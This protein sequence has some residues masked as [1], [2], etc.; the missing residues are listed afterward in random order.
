MPTYASL[1]IGEVVTGGKQQAD[2][3]EREY[4]WFCADIDTVSLFFF[5]LF[6]FL[7]FSSWAFSS[8]CRLNCSSSSKCIS[9]SGSPSAP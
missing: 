8:S 6:L 1:G 2:E 9:A 5:F 3:K 4:V 7:T